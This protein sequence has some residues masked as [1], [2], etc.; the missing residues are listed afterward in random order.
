M[1]NILLAS[2]LSTSVL[3]AGGNIKDL[4]LKVG[5]GNINIGS[6]FSTAI[7]I[8]AEYTLIEEKNYYKTNPYNFYLD[9]SFANSKDGLLSFIGIGGR[10][11]IVPKLKVG[12]TIG[13]SV[14]SASSS[15][16]SSDLSA[17]TYGLSGKYEFNDKHSLILDYKM[18]TLEDATST[19]ELDLD[20]TSISYSYSF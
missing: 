7:V 9:S 4:D 13:L 16:S 19:I 10:Y 17:I 20:T 3:L 11:E 14:Y 18:G 1:K 5:A 6:S 12:A 15:T 2:V 8:G